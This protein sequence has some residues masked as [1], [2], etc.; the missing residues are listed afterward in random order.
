MTKASEMSSSNPELEQLRN[1][2]T[3]ELGDLFSVYYERLDRMVDFRLDGRLRGR[4]DSTDVL[5]EAYLV[6]SRRID[7]YVAR[8]DV[9]LYV[10]MRQLTL[11]TLIDVQRR[12]FGQK[13]S[14]NQE[15]AI[16]LGQRDQTSLSIADAICAQWS[17]PSR[18]AIREEEVQQL[19][20]A[21]AS[22]D[23]IDREVLALRHFEHLTNTEVAE[24]LGLTATAASNRYVRAMTR[25]TELMQRLAGDS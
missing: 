11:Q 7:D 13:R 3:A 5:Q 18:A 1:G 23:E 12:H 22:M 2:G 14:P 17:S 24:T 20:Q 21:L 6:I 25:L 15:V 8:P 4:V 16:G 9:S 10:W 19:R